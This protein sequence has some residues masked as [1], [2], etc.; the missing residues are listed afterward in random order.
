MLRH[1]GHARQHRALL[2]PEQQPQHQP[3][4]PPP[5][6][7]PVSQH[8]PGPQLLQYVPADGLALTVRV[9]GKD[10][11]GRTPRSGGQRIHMWCRPAAGLPLHG[12]ALIWQHRALPGWQ[13][14]DMAIAGDHLESSLHLSWGRCRHYTEVCR[15]CCPRMYMVIIAQRHTELA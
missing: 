7:P 4:P 15:R 9:S 6:H 3:A 5:P 11:A 10:Y 2:Q 13:V 12:K 14:L 1:S 8:P